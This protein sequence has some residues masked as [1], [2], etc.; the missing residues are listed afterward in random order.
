LILVCWEQSSLYKSTL[1]ALREFP[2]DKFNEAFFSPGPFLLQPH[3]SI[4]IGKLASNDLA[5]RI[6]ELIARQV[7]LFIEKVVTNHEEAAIHYNL[8]V[9]P[10]GKRRESFGVLTIVTSWWS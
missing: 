3:C 4:E 8:P 1:N 9:P 7:Q 10:D 5:P 2:L 6:R